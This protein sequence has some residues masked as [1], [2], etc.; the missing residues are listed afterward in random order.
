[1]VL[2]GFVGCRWYIRRGFWRLGLVGYLGFLLFGG[3]FGY[4]C[5]WVGLVVGVGCIGVGGLWWLWVM[6]CVWLVF[7]LVLGW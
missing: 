2:W 7:A 4:L 5:V 3:L 1:V 6:L